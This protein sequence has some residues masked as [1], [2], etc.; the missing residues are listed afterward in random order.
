MTHWQVGVRPPEPIDKG[1][2]GAL[3][4]A[5]LARMQHT[6]PPGARAGVR[7]TPLTPARTHPA[8]QMEEI[9]IVH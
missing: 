6:A 9:R 3:V 8:C 4:F 5:E 2:R 1:R 7:C